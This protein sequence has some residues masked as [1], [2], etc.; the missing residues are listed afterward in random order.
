MSPE[1]SSLSRRHSVHSGAT[2]KP[3]TSWQISWQSSHSLVLSSF[4]GFLRGRRSRKLGVWFASGRTD[5]LVD[6][7]CHSIHGIRLAIGCLEAYCGDRVHTTLLAPPERWENKKWRKFMLENSISFRPVH[8]ASKEASEP[9]D[10]AITK[11]I[12]NMS[13]LQASNIAILTE[14]ADFIDAVLDLRMSSTK[15]TVTALIPEN[16]FG[17]IRKYQQQGVAVLEVPLPRHAQCTMVRA[18]LHEDGGSVKLADP[19]EP[20]SPDIYIPAQNA[21]AKN[22]EALGYGNESE[23]SLAK[24]CAKFWFA[25]QLGPLTVF[26]HPLAVMALHRFFT[27]SEA[28]MARSWERYSGKLA[29]FLPISSRGGKLSKHQ[30]KM[31]GFVRARGVFKGGGPFMLEDSSDLVVIALR[32]LGFLDEDFN[33]DVPEA[34]FLFINLAENK[35]PLRK[36]GMLPCP[37]DNHLDVDRKL[38]CAFLSHATTEM[39]QIKSPKMMKPVLQVLRKAK[40]L[41]SHIDAEYSMEETFEA[42]K[43]YAKQQQLPVMRT[44]NALAWRIHRH[45]ETSPTTRSVIDFRL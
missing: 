25:N 7:D 38:R 21:V 11:H 29:Y 12:R 23:G 34:M 33:T 42:M 43:L 14:D 27:E 41:P 22:L 8:R 35:K 24:K 16:L 19:Y 20:I 45:N 13:K 39:W 15:I 9:N 26:P 37:G 18:I 6:G 4:V 5:L 40:L 30:E 32:R 3:K 10:E 44:L 36:C 2:P 28:V 17:V 31:Y 1:A